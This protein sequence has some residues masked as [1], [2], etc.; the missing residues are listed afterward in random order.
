MTTII[1][2]PEKLSTAE[3]TNVLRGK[4]S[5]NPILLEDAEDMDALMDGLSPARRNL[6]ITAIELYKRMLVKKMDKK[7][8]SSSYDIYM[9]MA[10][11][12]S[13]KPLEEFR[14]LLLNQ[15]NRLIKHV[16]ISKGGI[17]QT[18][19]DVRVILR[20]ALMCRATQ[21]ILVH[22]HPSGNKRPSQEDKRLTAAVK[23]SA[24]IMNIRVTDH[25]IITN[26]DFF[27]FNDEGMI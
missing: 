15:S 7:V 14:I 10:P 8:I 19:A 26:G 16:C 6:A 22:N 13:D 3:L 1:R 17:D 20:E 11:I 24:E 21:I 4:T 9:I 18:T 23:K 27:S 12:L 5:W 2:E 25:V